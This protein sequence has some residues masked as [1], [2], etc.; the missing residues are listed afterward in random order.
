MAELDAAAESDLT[1]L[2]VE[3]PEAHL[4]PQLQKLLLCYLQRRARESRRKVPADPMEPAGHLQ[5][6]VTTH[7]PVLSAATSVEDVTIMARC[8]AEAS[9]SW[10]TRPLPVPQQ[11][12]PDPPQRTTAQ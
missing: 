10:Q 3:E 11:R 7:F 12:S 6:L 9:G 5:V 2:L 8:P 1:V 4:H